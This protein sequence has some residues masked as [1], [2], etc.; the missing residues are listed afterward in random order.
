MIVYQENLDY[1]KH[2]K[3]PFG[4]YVLA[5]N[6]PNPTNM[7][8]PMCLYFIYLWAEDSTQGGHE[9]LHL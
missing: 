6:E 2:L 7:N 5:N 8:A 4:T 9:H 1:E 3:I